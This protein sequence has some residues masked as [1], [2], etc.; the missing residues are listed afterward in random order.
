MNVKERLQKLQDESYYII[1]KAL[2]KEQM[3]SEDWIRIKHIDRDWE[4]IKAVDVKCIHTIPDELLN[5][6]VVKER[7]LMIG[8]SLALDLY[9]NL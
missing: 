5:K 1:H 6:E 2:G 9:I 3:M 8:K 4:N 7:C